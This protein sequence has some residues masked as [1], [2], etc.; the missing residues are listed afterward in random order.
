MKNSLK[1]VSALLIAI[2]LFSLL[3]TSFA[4]DSATPT[5]TVLPTETETLPD[6]SENYGRIPEVLP[7][8]AKPS[9]PKRSDPLPSRYDSRD[10]GYVTP[11]RNQGAYGTCWA[12]GAIACIESN[13]LKKGLRIKGTPVTASTLDLSESQLAWFTYTDAYDALGMLTGDKV[14]IS[15]NY[16][17]QGGNGQLAGLSLMRWT[18]AASEE[19]P[20]LAYA[21]VSE[22]GLSADYAYDYDVAHVQSV[23]QIPASDTEAVKRAIMEYGA[24]TMAYYFY[25]NEFTLDI[26]YENLQT[27]GYYCPGVTGTNHDVTVVGWD[28]SYSRENFNAA[29]RPEHDGAWIVKN[30]WDNYNSL[31]GYF[32]LSYE[33]P[34]SMSHG[35]YFYDVEPAD[36]YDYNYQYDGTVMAN[37]GITLQPGGS[38]GNIFTANGDEL[39]EAVS[40]CHLAGGFDYKVQ[41]YTGVRD[42]TTAN[43]SSGTL[44]YEQTGSFPYPGYHTV[45]LDT[46]VQLTASERF[47]VVFIT[48][49]EVSIN[50]D[51]TAG[52][53]THVSHP[54][55]SYARQKSTNYWGQAP[56]NSN[57]RIKAYTSDLPS[58]CEHLHTELRN[59][60]EAT[61]TAPGNEGDTY[62]L[63]CGALVAAGAVIPALGHDLIITPAVPATCTEPGSTQG[64]AC[65]R[66]AYEVLPQTVP[67]LGHSYVGGI[68]EHCGAAQEFCAHSFSG[69]QCI[70]CGAVYRIRSVSL[71]LSDNI[72][73]IFKAE[74]P[75]DLHDP[76]I[77]FTLNG[78]ETVIRGGAPDNGIYSFEFPDI[79]PQ[80]MG[81][82]IRCVLHATGLDETEYTYVLSSYSLSDYCVN[83]MRANPDNGKLIRLLSDLIAYGT[84]AQ[85][86]EGYNVEHLV[87]EDLSTFDP[88]TFPGL[89]GKAVSFEG[90]V[91]PGYL[92]TGASAVLKNCIGIRVY[93][94]AESLDGLQV[95]CR[96]GNRTT[97]CLSSMIKAD[98]N[99]GYYVDFRDIRATEFDSPV[100]FKLLRNGT[101][102]GQTLT[103]SVNTYV[104]KMQSSRIPGLADLVQTI[105]NYG[106]SA[107]AYAAG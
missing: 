97:T 17:Q 60:I 41:I 39:L 81:D 31:G 43:P 61:C 18:G 59:V 101:Q 42:F 33:N 93:F 32:Y 30:S 19:E 91:D 105:Y 77:V 106:V 69:V 62:C 7:D 11:V 55:C 78:N 107:K 44:A 29:Y 75:E 20:A 28:D 9:T 104:C 46:P 51:L 72:N 49:D 50:V 38:V 58:A 90:T 37:Y 63:D 54:S 73:M 47:S 87:M 23:T 35:C 3:P 21:N 10:Y 71:R 26:P 48:E 88:S 56:N 27:G 14:T 102:L 86:Y 36:N 64:E 79:A 76:Y 70:H 96:I 98:G 67:A 8:A 82:S 92:W 85:L 13:M 2:L 53:Y 24:G 34:A 15:N 16:L 99:G 4:A 65:S 6:G 1:L 95:Q 74:I 66:C 45:K 83:M 5:L 94:R 12:H 80:Y 89:S 100:T 22:D 25:Q 84:A 40:V 68:C 103:Y 52:N 57:L